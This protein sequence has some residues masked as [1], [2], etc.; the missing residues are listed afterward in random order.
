MSASPFDSPTVCEVLDIFY[1]DM[2]HEPDFAAI[3]ARL[4]QTHEPLY[5]VAVDLLRA[6]WIIYEDLEAGQAKLFAVKHGL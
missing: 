3:R 2:E 1:A 5:S 4:M 6:A